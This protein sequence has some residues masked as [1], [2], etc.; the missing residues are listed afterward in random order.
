MWAFISKL[1]DSISSRLVF[2]SLVEKLTNF[3]PD[4]QTLNLDLNAEMCLKEGS[5]YARLDYKPWEVGIVALMCQL[6]SCKFNTK[7]VRKISTCKAQ[8]NSTVKGFKVVLLY[9]LTLRSVVS[10]L[11]L[12][13]ICFAYSW[14]TL[15]LINTCTHNKS[16]ATTYSSAN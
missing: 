5:L 3:K 12:F 9:Y 1:S 7:F 15:Y 6:V 11:S 4:F 8:I 16:V 13:Q 14:F 2:V 10:V